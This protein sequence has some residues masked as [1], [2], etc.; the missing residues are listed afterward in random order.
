M[1]PILSNRA[2]LGLYLVSW[3]PIGLVL[4]YWPVTTG[5]LNWWESL[6]VIFPPLAI[7][8]F[9][10]LSPWYLCQILPLNRTPGYRLVGNHF[11]AASTAA[12][13]WVLAFVAHTNTLSKSFA[14]METVAERFRHFWA[15]FYF[16]G[17]LLYLLSVAL[18]YLLSSVETSQRAQTL[19]RESELKALKM[20]INPHFLFNSLNSISALTTVDGARAR[21]MCIKLSEFLRSTLNL[22][23]RESIPLSEELTL[24]KTYLE[25]EQIRFGKRLQVEQKIDEGC[26]S[27]V[28]PALIVQPLVENAIKHGISSMLDGGTVRLEVHCESGNL[29]ILVTNP[30]DPESPSARRNGIGLSNIRQRLAARYGDTARLSIGASGTLYVAELWLPCASHKVV[31]PAKTETAATA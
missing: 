26:G 2:H 22:G 17:I 12:A 16:V 24:S 23:D 6:M 5:A 19:A 20:Q 28:V 7:Y 3:I 10:C 21:Q 31:T 30:F 8:A 29:R 15:P 27:C 1:H 25:V 13:L 14:T 4:V 11:A 18:H 9:L